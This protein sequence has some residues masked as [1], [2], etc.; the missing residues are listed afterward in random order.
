MIQ[1]W[2]RRSLKK[3]AYREASFRLQLALGEFD[4][5]TLSECLTSEAKEQLFTMVSDIASSLR[6]KG[7]K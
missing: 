7:Q 6:A 2:P 5:W 4:T 3:M 1:H